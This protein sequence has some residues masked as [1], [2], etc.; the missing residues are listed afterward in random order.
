MTITYNKLVRD[1]IPEIIQSSGKKCS[2]EILSDEEYL[3]LFL[4]AKKIEGC[5]EKTLK[6]YQT[7]IDSMVSYVG[8]SVRHILTEDLRLY[9]TEYQ[10][11]HQSSRVTIDN[12]RRILSSFFSDLNGIFISFRSILIRS[13]FFLCYDLHEQNLYT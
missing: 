12:I 2:T 1:R 11:V 13:L 10:R 3:K 6:Y 4:D 9:L 5:S 7:T 8:K